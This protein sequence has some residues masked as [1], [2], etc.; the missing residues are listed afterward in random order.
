MIK[1]SKLFSFVCSNI[2]P[3]ESLELLADWNIKWNAAVIF[4][5]IV[6]ARRIVTERDTR[7]T[8]QR[9]PQTREERTTQSGTLNDELHGTD[10]KFSQFKKQLLKA[11]LKHQSFYDTA[12]PW[13]KKGIEKCSSFSS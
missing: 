4:I 6:T 8:M 1:N 3:A 10:Q 7:K 5:D 2:L 13:K 12:H 11:A 9:K